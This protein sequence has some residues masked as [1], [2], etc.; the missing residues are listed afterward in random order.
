[1]RRLF[2]GFPHEKCPTRTRGDH[3]PRGG[4]Y[5]NDPMGVI[6]VARSGTIGLFD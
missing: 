3:T 6:T 2:E 1:M 5:S 4:A